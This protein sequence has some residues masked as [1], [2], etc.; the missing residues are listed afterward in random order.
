MRPMSLLELRIGTDSGVW[1]EG[2]GNRGG[3]LRW[4]LREQLLHDADFGG[5]Y[6][7]DVVREHVHVDFL[8]CE[9]GSEKVFHHFQRTDVVLDHVAEIGA[10]ER[11]ALGSLELLH[12]CRRQH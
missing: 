1:Y 12:L 4:E 5:L 2:T 9:R 8:S 11:D 7:D 10:V 3:S 6:R